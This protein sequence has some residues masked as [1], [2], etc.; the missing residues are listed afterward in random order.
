MDLP[1]DKRVH[2]RYT[3]ERLGNYGHHIRAEYLQKLKNN[4][5]YVLISNADN[6][7]MPDFLMRAIIALE[8]NENAVASYCS[9]IVH[10]YTGWQVMNCKLQ[11]GYI[12]CGQVLLK[13]KESAEVGWNSLEHSSDWTFFEDIAKKYGKNSFVQFE[14]CHFVHN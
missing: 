10:N 7:Y 2:F 11:R 9:Q 5:K 8:S 6:Y 14:G 13:A 4:G 12:D 3:L 1:K